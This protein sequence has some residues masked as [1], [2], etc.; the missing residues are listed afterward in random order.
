MKR[1]FKNFRQLF[2]RK[3][4][5]KNKEKRYFILDEV[6]WKGV[7]ETSIF[8]SLAYIPVGFALNHTNI[9][10]HSAKFFVGFFCIT[11]IAMLIIKVFKIDSK[12]WN[13]YKGGKLVLKSKKFFL[14]VTV[15]AFILSTIMTIVGIATHHIHDFL[16]KD[17]QILKFFIL[18][19]VADFV[20]ATLADGIQAE[21]RKFKEADGK[22][23]LLSIV[24]L[25]LMLLKAF[26]EMS[27][28]R[29]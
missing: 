1:I 11:F 29:S 10:I 15:P 24:V 17:F 7:W 8:I 14:I 2:N 21:Y 4:N 12:K 3:Q 22:G 26:Y 16:L 27:L 5:L 18:C 19:C 25:I 13:P 6:M 23:K 9:L 20:F 28:D